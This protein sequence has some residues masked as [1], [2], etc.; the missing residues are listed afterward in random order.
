MY[1]SHYR[2]LQE[3]RPEWHLSTHISVLPESPMSSKKH[4]TGVLAK[5]APL[6]RT[7]IF[8]GSQQTFQWCSR[9]PCRSHI[10][11]SSR[12]SVPGVPED[13]VGVPPSPVASQST[14][15]ESRRP[16]LASHSTLQEP[17][18]P[19]RAS[20]SALQDPHQS[21]PSRPGVPR[22]LREQP[23]GAAPPSAPSA[24]RISRRAA[25]S[26]SVS[27]APAVD[28]RGALVEHRPRDPLRPRFLRHGALRSHR[29]PAGRH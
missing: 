6:S 16:H 5:V 22:S 25:A 20:Q 27:R 15:Q 9:A 10:N 18:R 12:S 17:R 29:E 11:L 26:P 4:P 23:P 28:G 3:S 1:I 2:V 14:L 24:I 19:Q 21:S 13:P 8:P 7:S